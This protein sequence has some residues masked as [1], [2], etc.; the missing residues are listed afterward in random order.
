DYSLLLRVQDGAGN[1]GQREIKI[2]VSDLSVATV[3]IA[4]GTKGVFYNQAIDARG[5][6]GS[7]SFRLTTGSL[8][9][10]VSFNS[11]T[12]AI[13]GIPTTTYSTTVGIRVTDSAGDSIIRSYTLN[14]YD[15]QITNPNVLANATFGL[16]YSAALSASPAGVYTWT[17]TG[18][19]NGLTIDS[20]TGLISG[21]PLTTG[22]FNVTVSA[23]T[24]S[25]VVNKTFT[26]IVN[27][28]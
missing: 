20:A 15:I 22:T 10:G 7:Y 18:L 2:H 12:G 5:G 14:V 11:A 16:A 3:N 8:P 21:T 1:F 28:L 25:T 17:A 26:L 6:T 24:S 4:S 19:P 23:G 9:S 13:S 27:L